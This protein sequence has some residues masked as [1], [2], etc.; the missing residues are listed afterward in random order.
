MRHTDGSGVG[1][2]GRRDIDKRVY[3][4]RILGLSG[5]NAQLLGSL[6]QFRLVFDRIG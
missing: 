2:S 4:A 6:L 3:L 5:Q 1:E